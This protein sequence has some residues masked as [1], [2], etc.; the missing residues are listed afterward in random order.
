[1]HRSVQLIVSG[2]IRSGADVAKAMA[3]GADAVAIGT[4]ALAQIHDTLAARTEQ[5][6]QAVMLGPTH[7]LI[8][9]Q[10]L[11]P[12]QKFIRATHLRVTAKR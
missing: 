9:D 11:I 1:M 6:Q 5:A 7:P 12:L 4:A 8:I 3:L 2:G 10:R